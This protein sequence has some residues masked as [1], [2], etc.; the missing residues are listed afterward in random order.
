MARTRKGKRA[1]RGLLIADHKG[2]PWIGRAVHF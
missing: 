1:L 2:A